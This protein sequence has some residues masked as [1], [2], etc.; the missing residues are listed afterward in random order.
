VLSAEDATVSPVPRKREPLPLERPARL[1]V[2]SLLLLLPLLPPETRGESMA[3]CAALIALLSALTWGRAGAR[4]E[5]LALLALGGCSVL[6]LLRAEAPGAAVEPLAT[7][8]V[9]VAAGLGASLLPASTRRGPLAPTALAVAGALLG[10]GAIYEKLWGL[11][12]RAARLAAEPLLADREA[13]IARLAEG[14]AFEPFATPAALGGFLALGLCVTL[15]CALECRGRRR[16][17]LL[18][19]VALE[20]LGLLCAASATALA[21][22]LVALAVVGLV[23]RRS[24]RGLLIGGTAVLVAIGAV[25]LIRGPK[26]WS[27]EDPDSPW[28]LRAGNFRVAW[29]MVQDRPWAGLG[30]GGFAE[31]YPQYRRPGDNE[32]RHAHS[33]PLE[34]GAELGVAGWLVATPLFFVLFAGPLLRRRPPDEPRWHEGLA[35]GLLVF[36][37]QNLADFTAFFPSLLWLAALGRGLLRRNDAAAVPTRDGV[38]LL[39]AGALAVVAG[40]AVLAGLGGLASDRRLAARQAGFAGERT[41]ARTH[42]ERATAL[43]PWNVDG[44]VQRAQSGLAADAEPSLDVLHA[45]LADVDRAIRLSPLRPEARWLRAR[46]RVGLGDGPGAYADLAAAARLYPMRESYAADRDRLFTAL[47][48]A[49]DRR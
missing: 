1:V 19:A 45:A 18:A 22:L 3:G 23:R 13:V 35:A 24:R 10:A 27:T 37:V 48:G 38:R 34:L 14:R 9:A 6:L 5:H 33:L 30:P 25:A 43:A 31:G 47:G 28:R 8:L 44:W 42:A 32:T 46:I 7:A 12:A 2:V 40:A 15:A 39:R 20:G 41:A 17:L 11:E 49:A 36:A 16:A 21:A 4:G 26:L 29:S